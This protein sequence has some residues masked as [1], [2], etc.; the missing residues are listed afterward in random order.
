M[1][2]ICRSALKS[3]SRQ[4]NQCIVYAMY[5]HTFDTRTA[6]LCDYKAAVMYMMMSVT[7]RVKLCHFMASQAA[8][9]KWKVVALDTN[10]SNKPIGHKL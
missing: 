9:G 7:G 5:M 3:L 10:K 6:R 1:Q 4:G 2:V 8:Q